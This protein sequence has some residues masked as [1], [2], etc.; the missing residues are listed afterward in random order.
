MR[1]DH[2]KF[3]RVLIV[4]EEMVTGE[5]DEEVGE[6]VCVCVQTKVDR[7]QLSLFTCSPACV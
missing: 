3:L 2:I 4:K 6:R 5:R 7:F 1:Q